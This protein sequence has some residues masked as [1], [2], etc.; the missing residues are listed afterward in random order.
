MSPAIII[1]SS[2]LYLALLFILAAY[3]GSE[4]GKQF[5]KNPYVYALSL[6]VYCTAWTFYGSV[7]RAAEQGIA[8]LPIYLGPTLF[9]PLWMIIL[10]KIVHISQYQRITSIADFL[11]SRYGKSISLGIIA[12]L[13]S[14]FAIVPYV[15]IQL[16]GIA[17]SFYVLL[18]QSNPYQG[19]TPL[20]FYL[21]PA[22]FI[23]IIMA[24][25]II[26]FGARKLDPN[27]KHEGLVGAI[28]AESLLKLIAFLAAGIFVTFGVFKGFGDLFS[29]GFSSDYIEAL[30]VF[31]G[32][33]TK[34]YQWF[35]LMLL[36]MFAVLLLPRQF[37]VAVVENNSTE[38]IRKASWVFPLYLLLIN[39]F[40][41]PIAIGGLLLFPEGSVS[42]DTFVLSI[43]LQANQMYLALF[44]AL[45]GFA[46][47]TSMVIVSVIALSIMLSNNLVLPILL[48]PKFFQQNRGG[49]LTGS[50][51]GIRRVSILLVLL[52]A[53]SYFRSIG[54]AYSLVSIGLISFT[55]IAQFAPPLIGG[56]YWKG[57][58]KKGAIAGL[59]IG[60]I[61]W[62]F[63]LAVPSLLEAS[64]GVSILMR[65]GL[66]GWSFLRPYA[67][68]GMQESN[69]I[70]HAAFWSL[71]LNTL[72]FFG[73]SLYSRASALELSQ[74]DIFVDI[75]KYRNTETQINLRKRKASIQDI[76]LLLDRFLGES[77]RREIF[78]FYER[79]KQ[80]DLGQLKTGSTD[81]VNLAETHL[82]G[83]IGASSAKILIGAVSK[84]DPISLEE[85]FKVLENTQEIIQ[86]SKALERKSE[87]LQSTTRK[88]R[89]ANEQLKE[90]ERL[91][92]D[93]ITT[94]THE[95]R[96]PITSM[97]AI[98]KIMLDNPNIEQ[99]QKSDFLNILV[100]ESARISRLINQV[101]DLEK[102]E[103]PAPLKAQPVDFRE[104]VQRSFDSLLTLAAEKGIQFQLKLKARSSLVLGDPDRLQQVVVNLLSN[105]IKFC[106]SQ[107]GKVWILL[108]DDEQQVYLSVKDNGK[109]IPRDKQQFIFERFTQLTDQQ[110]GK[111]TGSGLGLFITHTIVK[112]H[113]GDLKVYSQH[114]EGANF[115]LSLPKFLLPLDALTYQ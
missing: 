28:A 114:G 6:G 45:G 37:H 100:Q 92:A 53:Y 35:W 64:E 7:G 69:H 110:A 75:Y 44:I 31:S 2:V 40:V 1:G 71:G 88:L 74:A 10:R 9:A 25:F 84:E 81:F 47:A 80:V 111:P 46:A 76:Q 89:K 17:N 11:S 98:S 58:T 91:K 21:D 3:L 62:L 108:T 39:V 83:S 86:Y 43:P 51:L 65:D 68:F 19:N 96:T 27:E 52:L 36:S 60:A 87:E 85:M 42:P 72:A 107:Q 12:S 29:R 101:L 22:L 115:M 99:Q 55:G 13:L 15:S 104:V 56:L 94:V 23:S 5:V 59:V 38:H 18:N 8:F 14:M 63:T 79:K 66:F 78:R 102:I 67:L 97:K 82:A 41:L 113:Q 112:N 61:V 106:D 34:G 54:Q 109:G 103:S 16:K 95:L 105:A 20:P 24:V 93:F 90:L 70:V 26:L 33:D 73:V 48:N 50:L 30:F 57:A 4:K 77:R 32:S 49:N